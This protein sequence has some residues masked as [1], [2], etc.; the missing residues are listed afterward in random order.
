MCN[1]CQKKNPIRL[2]SGDIGVVQSS[3]YA[4]MTTLERRDACLVL[5]VLL[6]SIMN[7]TS[8]YILE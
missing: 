1:G 4:D 5:S 8:L 3:R 2:C 6:Y 7:K